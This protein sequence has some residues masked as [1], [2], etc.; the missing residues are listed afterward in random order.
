[1]SRKDPKTYASKPLVDFLQIIGVCAFA[2]AQPIY[3][4]MS[5]NGEFFV[6]HRSSPLDLVV[7]AVLLA[8][9]VPTVLILL[10]TWPL[11][12]ALVFVRHCTRSFCW[13][14][15]LSLFCLS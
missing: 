13:R 10:S 5:K 9:G 1:M 2:V 12:S 4:L 3:A 11:R 7:L 8:L 6:A 14:R 15:L